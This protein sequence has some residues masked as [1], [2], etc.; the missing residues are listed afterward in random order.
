MDVIVNIIKVTLLSIIEGVTE[1]LPISSTGH[2][3][4][5][6]QWIGLDPQG[7]ANAFNII[8]QL[9]AILSVIVIYWK[10]LNPWHSEDPR[11]AQKPKRYAQW[12]KQT[13]LYYMLTH[14][15]PRTMA[16]WLRVVVAVIPSAVVGIL[17][18]DVI[19]EHLM[20]M[21]VVTFTLLFYGVVMIFVES[22]NAKR[23]TAQYEDPLDFSLQT[24]FMIGLFQCLAL[25]PGTSRSAATIIGAMVLGSS[26]VA[27][28]EFSFFMAIPSMMGATLLKVIKNLG[29]FTLGQ[30]LLI[31]LGFVLSFI[32]A[33]V[34]IQ[35]F[36]AYVQKKDFKVF[37]YYSIGLSALLLLYML[38]GM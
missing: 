4:L 24:A 1:F 26:R 28:A 19:D 25:V 2:L 6:N 22:W 35:K 12:N 31:P 33:Y 38:F 16:L 14:V 21:P 17:F 10:R 15:N 7:F 3:I 13:R 23:K 32:V 34:V 18:D 5:A 11:F 27:A 20:T 36:M 9:G 29:G 30:W 37:G 8:I